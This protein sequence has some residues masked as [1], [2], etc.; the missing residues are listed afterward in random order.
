MDIKEIIIWCLNEHREQEYLDFPDKMFDELDNE[1][2]KKIVAE[3]KHRALFKLPK[4]EIAFQEWL[5][6]NDRHIWDDLWS[7]ELHEPYIVSIIF[8]PNLVERDGR[9]FPICDLERNDNYFFNEKHMTDEESKV[10]IETS[11]VRFKDHKEL[12]VAQLLALE[13]SV[14][15][16]D[17]WH[18]AYKYKI[19]IAAAKQAVEDL[20]DDFALVH[21]TDAEHLA[22]FMEE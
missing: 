19:S 1:S 20:K 15:P 8:L 18:F 17:I 7:C 11:R 22:K 16:I 10:Y 4:Y 14:G 9:G 21:L 5:K 6:E 12:T 13:I 2:A 3:L